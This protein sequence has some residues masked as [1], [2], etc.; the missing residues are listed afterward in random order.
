MSICSV[1][2][3]VGS[4]GEFCLPTTRLDE[5]VLGPTDTDGVQSCESRYSGEPLDRE[6]SKSCDLR[7]KVPSSSDLVFSRGESRETISKI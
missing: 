2:S 5:K 7:I 1:T 3:G 6:N 4:R